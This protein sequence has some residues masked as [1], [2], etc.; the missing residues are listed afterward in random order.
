MLITPLASL[1]KRPVAAQAAASLARA[2]ARPEMH[3]EVDSGS[4]CCKYAWCEGS[5]K[6]IHLPATR[7]SRRAISPGWQIQQVN[8]S[9]FVQNIQELLKVSESG[10]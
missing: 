10:R 7:R 9:P 3:N 8:T 1:P 6:C 4:T 2:P 5:T